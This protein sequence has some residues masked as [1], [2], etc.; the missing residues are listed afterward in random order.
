VIILYTD[1]TPVGLDLLIVVSPA[2]LAVPSVFFS[3]GLMAGVVMIKRGNPSVNYTKVP[4]ALMNDTSLS[5]EARGVLVYLLSKPAEWVVR[6]ADIEK[7]GQIG[8]E[9]RQRIIKELVGSQYL[10]KDQLRGGD[11]Q[12]AGVD[13]HVY[14]EPLPEK[15]LT[16]N[17]LTENPSGGKHA[18]IKDIPLEKKES[19]KIKKDTDTVVYDGNGFSNMVDV[20]DLD[21]F[22]MWWNAYP[23]HTGTAQ[24]KKAYREARKI[25]DA[26]TLL[27]GAEAYM[28]ATAGTDKQ[29][30]KA[31]ANWLRE[32]LW[33]DHKPEPRSIYILDGNEILMTAEE[34]RD[35][36]GAYLRKGV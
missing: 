36:P 25:T 4:N 26:A 24:A 3:G 1:G 19:K 12:F 2:A 9:K 5:F 10:I 16:E 11:N 30:I 29:Y 32:E 21:D 8:K 15:P 28:A 23:K 31:P 22:G 20:L 13:Y 35:V 7:Q 34:A 18:P 17:P 14:D 33:E 6:M 27:R